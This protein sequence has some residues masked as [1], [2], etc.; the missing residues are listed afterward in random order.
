MARRSRPASPRTLY[1]HGEFCMFL[2]LPA[3]QFRNNIVKSAMLQEGSAR[4]KLPRTDETCP[5][6][7]V[8][9]EKI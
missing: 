7:D 6:P 3:V 8:M 2:G 4:S 5:C 9:E 1:W